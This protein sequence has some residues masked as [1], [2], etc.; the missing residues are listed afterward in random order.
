VDFFDDDP[1]AT[2]RARFGLGVLRDDLPVEPLA[3]ALLGVIT[4]YG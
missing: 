4:F 1:Y 2:V 3:G